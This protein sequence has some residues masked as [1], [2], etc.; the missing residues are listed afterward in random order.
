MHLL[1]PA[2]FAGLPL[3]GKRVAVLAQAPL[4]QSPRMTAQAWML[5]EAGAEVRVVAYGNAADFPAPHPRIRLYAIAGP[6]RDTVVRSAWPFLHTISRITGMMRQLRQTLRAACDDADLLLAQAPPVLP[7][8]WLASH[9][10]APL[11]IDWHNLSAPLAALKFGRRHP[12]VHFLKYVETAM[13]RRAQGHF[14]VTKALAEHLSSRF[15]KVVHALPDRPS[16]AMD[17]AVASPLRPLDDNRTWYTAVS[18]TSWS[19]DEAMD[20]LL[21]AV[22]SIDIPSGKGLRL[23]VTGKGP[24]R[25]AFEDRAAAM[26]RPGL[27]VETTWY[28]PT[29]YCGLLKHAH[30]G[31]SLHRSASGLDFPMKII[32]M[33]AAGLPVLALDYGPALRDGLIGLTGAATFTDAAGLAVQLEQRLAAG[34][35]PRSAP[36]ARDWPAMWSRVALP[37]MLELM[38]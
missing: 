37:A 8:I 28:S 30:C 12:A 34:I 25:D 1:R 32:D 20:V 6:G 2:K 18:P 22:S 7:G 14:A 24:L 33:E 10:R 13:G 35:W 36:R 3:E 23:V 19:R 16:L 11:V 17:N 15:P 5:A 31:L 38:S 4:D 26:Q 21:D 29:D 9:Q 27:Q